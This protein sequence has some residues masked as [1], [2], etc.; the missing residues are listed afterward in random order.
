MIVLDSHSFTFH[1]TMHAGRSNCVAQPREAKSFAIGKLTAKDAKIAKKK[2]WNV[3]R[4]DAKAQ[5]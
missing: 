2:N 5:R 1:T 4:K 3:S